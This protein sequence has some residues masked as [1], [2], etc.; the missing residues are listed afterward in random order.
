MDG[1]LS[2]AELE[3]LNTRIAANADKLIARTQKKLYTFTERVSGKQPASFQNII[4]P[5]IGGVMYEEDDKWPLW[6][7]DPV[8]GVSRLDWGGSL[9][10]SKKK[11]L[12]CFSQLDTINASAISHLLL[13]EKRQA[14]RY[15]K[16]C[17][18]LHERLVDNWC[19][20]EVRWLH[21]PETFI[22]P[23]SENVR[24]ITEIDK[25]E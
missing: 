14:Q 12:Q 7:D 20:D 22:Y 18:L 15:Y 21:Y 23:R 9:P 25:E 19:N 5:E 8:S 11:I 1:L 4:K 6:L 16:A 3:A 13:V 10:L 2:Q 17:E 24:D